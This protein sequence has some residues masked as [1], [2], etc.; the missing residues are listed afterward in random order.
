LKEVKP[1]RSDPQPK[2]IDSLIEVFEKGN[3]AAF[4]YLDSVRMNRQDKDVL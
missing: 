1:I 2:P 3:A 4:G